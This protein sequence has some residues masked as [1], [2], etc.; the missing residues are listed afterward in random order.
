MTD[1]DVLLDEHVGRV[2][3]RVLAERG[4]EVQQ[5]KDRFGEET[6][7]PTLVRWCGE[8]GVILVTNNAKDF[9][10]LHEDI[11]HAG[12]FLYR[13]QSLP[14]DDPEGLARAVDEVVS[15]YGYR[16]LT[17]EIAELDEWYELFHE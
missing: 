17:D 16:A 4:Y 1:P 6:E 15:Q 2:F 14:D 10:P 9:E 8:N 12:L 13:E 5:A 11:E 3:E 7:D